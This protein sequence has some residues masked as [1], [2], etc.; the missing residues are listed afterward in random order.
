MSKFEEIKVGDKVVIRPSDD[1]RVS[2][3]QLLKTAEVTK[4][5]ATQITAGGVRFK[6]R[7]GWEY[8]QD[9]YA[10]RI[11]TVWDNDKGDRL[12]TPE[13]AE[14]R[15][16][17]VKREIDHRDLAYRIRDIKFIEYPYETLL[18]LAEV[19]GLEVPNDPQS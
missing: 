7:T 19:L 3:P 12:M 11:E 18:K 4:V 13:E 5:T 8:G 10:D 9:R 6:R 2:G 15:N 17:E 1:W 14:A 16:K